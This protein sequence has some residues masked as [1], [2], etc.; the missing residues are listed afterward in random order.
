MDVALMIEGQ[1]GLNWARW[2]RIARAAEELG[3]AG[4]YR[5]DHF[6]NPNPP[7]LDSLDLWPSLTWLASHTTRIEFGPLVLPI[8]FRHPVMVAREASAIDDLSGGRLQLGLGGGWQEREHATYGFDL[9]PVPER[10]A[11]FEEGVE[12]VT[13]LLKSETPVSFSGTYYTLRDA[14]LLPRPQRKGGPPIVI[15]GKRL[16]LPLVAR[17]ADEW[18][19]PF[20]PPERIQALSTRLDELLQERGRAPEDVRRSVMSG[21]V[22]GRNDQ[23]LQQNALLKRR[24]AEELLAAG[25]FVGTPSA[26]VDQLGKLAEIGMQRVMLQWLDLDNIDG[27]EALAHGVLPQ[28]Q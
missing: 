18:N 22:F 2:Q 11:R 16:V 15:G 14:T 7:D 19:V 8:S 10:M 6:T 1:N 28:I 4:L 9:L 26:L 12:V 21:L 20:T 25:L 3:F 24:S 17:Y 13:R 23:E 27:L 5:S